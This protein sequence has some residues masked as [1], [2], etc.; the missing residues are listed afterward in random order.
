M[1]NTSSRNPPHASKA[2]PAVNVRTMRRYP[3]TIVVVAVRGCVVG[4][5]QCRR[6]QNEDSKPRD[7]ADLQRHWGSVVLPTKHSRL[8]TPLAELGRTVGRSRD[9]R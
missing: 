3:G 9:C 4:D 2:R 7:L 6:D 5:D 8:L 1:E